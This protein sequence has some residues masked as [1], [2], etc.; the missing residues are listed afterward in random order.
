M[1]DRAI[2][3]ARKAMLK[4]IEDKLNSILH[5]SSNHL[6]SKTIQRGEGLRRCWIAKICRGGSCSAMIPPESTNC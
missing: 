4:I 5:P 6:Q 3:G 2:G 1:C